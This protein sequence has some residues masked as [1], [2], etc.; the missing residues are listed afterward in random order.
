MRSLAPSGTT[1]ASMALRMFALRLSASAIAVSIEDVSTPASSTMAACAHSASVPAV[2]GSAKHS[3]RASLTVP[4]TRSLA[5]RHSWPA[6]VG[7][8]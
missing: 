6:P 3:A 8:L 7:T 4:S 2:D 5:T 1:P